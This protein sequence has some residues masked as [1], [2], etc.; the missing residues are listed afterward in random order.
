[1][2]AAA[3]VEHISLDTQVFVATSFG[4][5]GKSLEALKKHLARVV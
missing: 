3:I 1:M 2:T 5:N 4:F